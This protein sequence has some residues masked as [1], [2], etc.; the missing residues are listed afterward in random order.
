MIY[1]KEYTHKGTISGYA[2]IC[3]R[4]LTPEPL[5]DVHIADEPNHGRRRTGV[6]SRPVSTKFVL[7]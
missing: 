3:V 4:D 1:W 6:S 7:L 2:Q 5:R